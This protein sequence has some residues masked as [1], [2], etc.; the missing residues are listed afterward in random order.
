M[1]SMAIITH[2]LGLDPRDGH[3]VM[4]AGPPPDLVI[5]HAA[6]A[7]A[8]LEGALHP[9]ALALHEGQAFERGFAGSVAERELD[10]VP[11]ADLAADDEMPAMRNGLLAVPQPDTLT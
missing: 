10:L 1:N 11:R 5:R 7:L 8:V 9:E 4:P 6:V 2:A 3:V